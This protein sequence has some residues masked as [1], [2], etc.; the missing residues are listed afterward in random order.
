MVGGKIIEAKSFR[1]TTRFWCV[2][3][4]GDECAVLAEDPSDGIMP[5]I[6]DDIWW[7]SGRIYFDN[8]MRSL[9][10]IGNSF[11]ASKHSV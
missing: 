4:D 5:K 7:Q 11:D 3:R 6:Y 10:K 2:D 8:D 9:R 1:G